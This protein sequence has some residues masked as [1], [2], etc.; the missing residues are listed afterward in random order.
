MQ[1]IPIVMIVLSGDEHVSCD[2]RR[3]CP[4]WDVSDIMQPNSVRF[5][6]SLGTMI[7]L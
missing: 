6:V 2:G 7:K 5:L 3:Q 4:D 1:F